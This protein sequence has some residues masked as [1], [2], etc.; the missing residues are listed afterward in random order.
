MRDFDKIHDFKS[1]Y[2]FG[3]I[4]FLICLL[5]NMKVSVEIPKNAVGIIMFA[6]G[7]FKSMNWLKY[8]REREL[9][10]FLFLQA[11]VLSIVLKKVSACSSIGQSSGL[12]IRGLGVRVPPGALK[13]PLSLF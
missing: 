10:R 9:F 2:P 13:F 8:L 4:H 12:R 11:L 3:T 1:K 6:D 7:V 5:S